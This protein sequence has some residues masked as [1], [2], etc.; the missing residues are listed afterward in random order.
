[1]IT[2]DNTSV[3]AAASF[4]ATILRGN[5]QGKFTVQS[6][7]SRLLVDVADIALELEGD[8]P[9]VRTCAAH[10]L[11]LALAFLIRRQFGNDDVAVHFH[12]ALSFHVVLLE[13]TLVN[14][15]IG[16]PNCPPSLP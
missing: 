6:A 16:E 8:H 13:S 4:F 7:E 2:V 1:M 15:P 12:G 5:L 3:Q 11:I 10:S 9:V 14:G